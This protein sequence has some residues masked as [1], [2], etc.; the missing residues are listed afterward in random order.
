MLRRIFTII[1]II[2]LCGAA[3]LL[4]F[5]NLSGAQHSGVLNN[6]YFSEVDSRDLGGSWDKTRWT[7][8]GICGVRLGRN[9]DCTGNSPAYPYSPRDNFDSLDNIPQTFIDNRNTYYYLSRFAYA[10]FLIGI[11]FAVLALVPTILSCCLHG[12]VTGIISS[13]FAG[14][15]LLFTAAGAAFTT[16]VHV[17]GRNAFNN[18]GMSSSLSTKTFGVLWAAVACLL[19]SFIWMCVVSASG[20]GKKY[21]KKYATDSHESYVEAKDSS[22]DSSR[23]QSMM[24]NNN[25]GYQNYQPPPTA[26]PG[27]KQSR[28]FFRRT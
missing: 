12:F 7:L 26:P 18:A 3:L 24:Y 13:I 8:Y 20:A 27:Q 1:P 21:K 23:H 9:N 28:F 17:M 6:F 15:S 5:I 4:F 16:A 14:I 2:L 10:F 11:I 25:D 19:I 22:S